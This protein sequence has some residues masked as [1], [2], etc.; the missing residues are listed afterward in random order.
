M[1]FLTLC[2][3]SFKDAGTLPLLKTKATVYGETY[4]LESALL[5]Q[6]RTIDVSDV[7]SKINVGGTL[8]PPTFGIYKSLFFIDFNYFL[9]SVADRGFFDGLN[10]LEIKQ[11]QFFVEKVRPQLDF[12]EV[13]PVAPE[14]ILVLPIGTPW[15]DL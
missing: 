11:V 3:N 12:F 1:H 13:P 10:Q 9:R 8:L 2:T 15:M 4:I 14:V 5:P 6:C 7:F